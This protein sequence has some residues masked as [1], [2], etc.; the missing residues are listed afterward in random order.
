MHHYKITNQK[1]SSSKYGLCEVCNTWVDNIYM[2]TEKKEY[3]I[4]RF[5]E[6][7]TYFGHYDCLLRVRK[8]S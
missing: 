7:N 6:Q 4:G 2:Q 8:T 1:V 5:S 3:Q